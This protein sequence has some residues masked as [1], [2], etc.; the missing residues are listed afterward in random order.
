MMRD[1]VLWICFALAASMAVFQ[2]ALF[3]GFVILSFAPFVAIA[4]MRVQPSSALWLA[5]LAGVTSDLFSADPFGIHAIC[6]TVTA[7]ASYRFRRLFFQGEPLQLCFFTAIYSMIFT[8]VL[9]SI[10]FLFDRRAPFGGEWSF[11]DFATMP[12]VDAAYAF[13]WFVGPLLF[14]EWL[15][16][17]CKTWQ[18]RRNG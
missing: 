5:A 2:S 10:L 14:F 9:V 7:A 15:K 13:F 11:L 12:L 4:C 3:P 16:K 1:P 6:M 17:Q 8:P 18:L